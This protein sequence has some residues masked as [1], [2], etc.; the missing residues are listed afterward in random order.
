MIDLFRLQ[1]VR[2]CKTDFGAEFNMNARRVF[3][4]APVNVVAFKNKIP[5]TGFVGAASRKVLNLGA[6]LRGC[7]CA[8]FAVV[9]PVVAKGGDSFFKKSRIFRDEIPVLQLPVSSVPAIN[10]LLAAIGYLWVAVR[11]VRRSDAVVIYNFFPEYIPACI[12]LR[13]FKKPAVLDIEDFPVAVLDLREIIGLISYPV[14]RGVCRKDVVAVSQ[15]VA[16]LSGSKKACVVH[17]IVAKSD[18]AV[19]IRPWLEDEVLR[20]HF[21]GTVVKDTGSE[22]FADAVRWL[23]EQHGD[24]RIEFVVTGFG[25]MAP[26]LELE[27]SRGQSAVDLKVYSDL[28]P[29]A[30]R[31]LLKTCHVSL[32]LKA[33]GSDVGLT[34]FP[35]KVIE[36]AG[37]GLLLVSTRVSDVP[38]IFEGAA[39]FLDDFSGI[40]L[41]RALLWVSAHRTESS[42]LAE[43]GA[44]KVRERF[45]YDAVG[46]RLSQFVFET[47]SHV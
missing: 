42:A 38:E 24:V 29:P 47:S 43:G 39:V 19:A 6:A 16:N 37:N 14:V 2:Y 44:R 3:W 27:S 22:V 40:S 10:R 15:Q 25:D 41:G 5:G 20:V 26:I 30:Y 28:G 35:S 7:G 33:P 31:S 45:S 9:M 21:G 11:W 36:I 34:T 13:L 4:F 18:K 32:C 23:R 8:A 1:G 12:Y 46:K 17:G